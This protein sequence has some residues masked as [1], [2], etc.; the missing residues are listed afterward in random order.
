MTVRLQNCLPTCLDKQTATC[1]RCL[2]FLLPQTVRTL[3]S[4]RM[5]VPFSRSKL[6]ASGHLAGH[7]SLNLFCTSQA[8]RSHGK[9]YCTGQDCRQRCTLIVS[10]ESGAHTSTTHHAPRT[11][12]KEDRE[13]SV[14]RLLKHDNS[15]GTILIPK[16]LPAFSWCMGIG[17]MSRIRIYISRYS[18]LCFPILPPTIPSPLRDLIPPV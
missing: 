2:P 15:V 9:L 5:A 18:A 4:R 6:Q 7:R 10:H 12:T 14:V 3:C 8:A 13:L 11:I 16:H 1:H 17:Y